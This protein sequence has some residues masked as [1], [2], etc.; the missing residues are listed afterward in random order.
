M[1]DTTGRAYTTR[2][3]LHMLS[4]RK[5][6]VIDDEKANIALMCGLLKDFCPQVEV[7][8]SA[9]SVEE[10]VALITESQPEIVYLDIR[11]H[12][13][14]GFELLNQ[15]KERNF[16]VIMA[17]AYDQYA[18]QAFK[19]AVIDYILKP[20]QIPDLILATNKALKRLE[21]KSSS[22]NLQKLIDQL[23]HPEVAK[24]SVPVDDGLEFIDIS[25][26]VRC[27]ARINYTYIYTN[28]GKKYIVAKT[29]KDFEDTL[30]K[31][32]FCRVHQSHIINL[33]YIKKYNRGKKASI[34]MHDDSIIEISTR[35]KDEFLAK[36]TKL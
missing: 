12:H 14:N 21:E 15:V 25:H 17:T 27:E 32:L 13:S 5:A 29:L 24:I 6:V 8:G 19:Y 35:K 33:N 36:I 4:R 31:N 11:M 3:V 34:V 22:N 23:A 16:E 26:I 9:E 10:G 20:I 1:P 30:P 28:N 2:T 18:I 7:I